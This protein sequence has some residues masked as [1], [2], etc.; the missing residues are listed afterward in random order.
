MP[1]L[2]R[3]AAAVDDFEAK[4]AAERDAA[5]AKAARRKPFGAKD[6]NALAGFTS[7]ERA[8]KRRAYDTAASAPRR[9]FP[10]K[11]ATRLP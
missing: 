9:R 7:D 10:K 8:E 5:D 4:L 2:A 11:T 3:H 6:P 1:G